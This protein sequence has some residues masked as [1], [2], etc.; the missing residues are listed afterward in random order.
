MNRNPACQQSAKTPFVA[1]VL[2]TAVFVGSSNA[3]TTITLGETRK[4]GYSDSGNGNLLLADGP[5]HLSQTAVLNRL[6]FWVDNASGQLELAI[7]DSGPNNNCK[8]GKLKAQTQPFN[9]NAN[10]WNTAAPN[11]PTTLAPGNYCLAYLP[12][13]DNLT[14]RKGMTGGIGDYWFSDPFGPMPTTFAATPAGPDGFHWSL[15]A[16]LTPGTPV[17]VISFNPS[18]PSIPANAPGGTVVATIQV[19]MSDGSAFTG[20]LGFGTPY[21]DDNATFTI[22]E[23]K[24]IVNPFGPGLSADANTTQDVTIVARQ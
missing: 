16:T 1:I 13:S 19:T 5:Y 23:S 11:S 14:F 3:Q 17:P 22:S 20:T 9:T 18:N 4:L 12:S 24:L 2:A 10:S 21:D 7:F 6:S 8:S 15:Y